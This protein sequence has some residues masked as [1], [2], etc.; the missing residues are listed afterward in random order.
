MSNLYEIVELVHLPQDDVIPDSETHMTYVNVDS[1][2][3][4][5]ICT[6]AQWDLLYWIYRLSDAAGSFEEFMNEFL[7]EVYESYKR[8]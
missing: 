6:G 8:R 4:P 1:G 3:L 7:T 5:I 2:I